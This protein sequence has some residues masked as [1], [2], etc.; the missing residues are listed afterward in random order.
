MKSS[1]VT[2]GSC[3][4]RVLLS[5][6]AGLPLETIDILS[7]FIGPDCALVLRATDIFGGKM[8]LGMRI[9]DQ[10]LETAVESDNSEP[11]GNPVE[12]FREFVTEG[13][14]IDVLL[15]LSN[16]RQPPACA[17]PVEMETVPGKRAYRIIADVTEAFRWQYMDALGVGPPISEKRPKGRAGFVSLFWKIISRQHIW[18]WRQ[19]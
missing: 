13:C 1:G 6:L 12:V 7:E 18:K 19:V 16:E 3:R 8:V 2:I 14:S 10:G 11:M 4:M 17:F 5:R 9:T 15:F